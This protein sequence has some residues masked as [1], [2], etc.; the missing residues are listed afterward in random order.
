MNNFEET[1]TGAGVIAL[2]AT[3]ASAKNMASLIT[4]GAIPLS[5]RCF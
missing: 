1:V 2:G 3:Q 4:V 5:A